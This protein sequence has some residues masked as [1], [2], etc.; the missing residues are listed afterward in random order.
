MTNPAVSVSLH[1]S[2]IAKR[3]YEGVLAENISLTRY[4]ALQAPISKLCEPFGAS[5]IVRRLFYND[6]TSRLLKR[7]TASFHLRIEQ[8]QSVIFTTEFRAQ[9]AGGVTG[10]L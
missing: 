7:V 2:I 10:A 1:L 3:I 5:G 6:L 4:G 9:Q 8:V